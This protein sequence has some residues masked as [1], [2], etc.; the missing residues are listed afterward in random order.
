LEGKSEL[1]QAA[2]RESLQE[3]LRVL[4][5]LH[6]A[7]WNSLGEGGCFASPGFGEFLAGMAQE[8]LAAGTLSLIWL[9]FE[10]QPIAADIGYYGKGGLFTYQGGISPDHLNL[11]PGRAII[12]AQMELAMQRNLTFID[13]L[14]GD[15]PYKSRFDTSRIDNVRYEITGRGPR[16]RLIQSMLQIGRAVKSLLG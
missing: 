8:K 13:F 7:R 2:D 14:R 16:A 11:E 10:D 4:E 5:T 15:E 12:K 9:T 1:H 6:A 3:G